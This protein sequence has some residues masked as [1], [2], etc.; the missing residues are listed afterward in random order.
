MVAEREGYSVRIIEGDMTRPLPFADASF[1]IV[2][3]PVSNCYVE[4]VRPI[5]RECFR[6]LKK[7]GI[8]LCGLDNGINYLFD[9][10]ETVV[11]RGLPFNPL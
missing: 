11:K 1:D 3:H 9:D 4:E 7:G 2:F 8:L 10:D 6:V 5:F